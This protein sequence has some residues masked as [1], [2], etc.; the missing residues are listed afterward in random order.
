[1]D[2]ELIGPLRYSKSESLHPFDVADDHLV[3]RSPR[4][5]PFNCKLGFER[6]IMTADRQG[7]RKLTWRLRNCVL[8]D[9]HDQPRDIWRATCASEPRGTFMAPLAFEWIVV[10]V[11]V[12]RQRHSAQDSVVQ[13]ALHDV[14]IVAFTRVEEHS[15]GPKDKPNA[16]TSLR[17]GVEVREVVVVSE[18]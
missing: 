15:P 3:F 14:D 5:A 8:P 4:E 9:G 2:F 17:I 7:D 16:C 13:G 10:K 18:S 1:M 6:A 11:A 12:T